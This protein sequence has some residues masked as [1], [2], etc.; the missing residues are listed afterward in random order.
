MEN[1]ETK[2]EEGEETSAVEETKEE[3]PEIPTE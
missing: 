1:E 2:K 3:T